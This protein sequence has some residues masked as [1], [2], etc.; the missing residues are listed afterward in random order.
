MSVLRN[1]AILRRA[2][3]GS[4][5]ASGQAH[6]C[7][8]PRAANEPRAPSKELRVATPHRFPAHGRTVRGTVSGASV[9]QTIRRLID[10][11]LLAR[12][13]AGRGECTTEPGHERTVHVV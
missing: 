2:L 7:P 1:R 9:A 10:V 4:A 8:P 5:G 3:A 6:A 11:L 13:R 12:R